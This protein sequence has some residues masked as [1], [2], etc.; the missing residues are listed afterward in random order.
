MDLRL[1]HR[2]IVV[3]EMG[4]I[5]KAAAK[6]NFSQPALTKSIRLLEERL[7]VTLI[8]RGPRGISLTP[9]GEKILKHAKLMEAEIRKLDGEIDVFKN[10]SMGHVRIGVPPGPGFLSTVMPIAATKMTRSGVRITL[11]VTMGTRAELIRQL[12]HGELD[13][14]ISTTADDETSSE[15]VQEKLY[16]DRRMIVV[17]SDHPLASEPEVSEEAL[18]GFSWIVQKQA[19]TVADAGLDELMDG[20]V[21]QNT[22]N[23]NSTQ[24]VKI[25]ILM[26]GWIGLVAHDAVRLEMHKGQLVEIEVPP[27]PIRNLLQKRIIE[28]SY[29]RDVPLYSSAAKLLRHIR[30]ACAEQYPPLAEDEDTDEDG[31][32]IAAAR[33]AA[34]V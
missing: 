7:D 28:V 33:R 10:N 32:T 29:R 12:L 22:I 20:E 2:F 13:F 5:N 17:A 8:V 31:A 6:L 3:A 18:R 26:H 24:F 11:D 30:T 14:I 27:G 4:S 9:I 19:S 23:S 25:M 15:L 34:A 1:L 21:S 16:Q